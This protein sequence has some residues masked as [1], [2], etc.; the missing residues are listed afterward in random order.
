M[1]RIIPKKLWDVP[2]G[3][4]LRK[5]REESGIG[6][7][8]ASNLISTQ[9]QVLARLDELKAGQEEFV[10]S[11]NKQLPDN[12]NVFPWPLIVSA[13]WNQ[14]HSN[15]L[16]IACELFPVAPWNMMLLPIDERSALVLDLPQHPGIYPDGLLDTAF[17]IIGGLHQE[18]ESAHAATTAELM[19]GNTACLRDVE[20]R[21]KVMVG[22]I[23]GLAR[24]LGIQTFGQEAMS[25]HELL[26]GR[27]L[28]W[29]SS[30]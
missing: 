17:G 7:N 29:P 26:F 18:F 5:L 27:M 25:Q 11:V 12:T 20:T 8:D 23:C 9:D 2:S 30:K 13:A 14:Q 1:A 15:F 3:S 19:K 4:V 16:L 21:Q 10:A 28:G 6:P 22:K 24:Q